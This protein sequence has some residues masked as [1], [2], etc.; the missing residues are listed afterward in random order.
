MR[1]TLLFA[2]CL[3]V[4]G[5]AMAHGNSVSVLMVRA[6]VRPSAVLKLE[7]SLP[8]L[9]ISAADIERGYVD[10]PAAALLRMTA[11]KFR[12]LIFLDGVPLISDGGAYRF[13][14]PGERSV[15]PVTLGIEL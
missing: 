15:V 5:T 14:L 13:Q 7:A 8:Q 1:K 6:E 12:P 9:V 2:A 10:I 11:G 3:S 4:C